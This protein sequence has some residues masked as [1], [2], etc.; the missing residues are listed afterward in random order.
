[1]KS[2]LISNVTVLAL[3]AICIIPARSGTIPENKNIGKRTQHR[4]HASESLGSSLQG[5]PHP[6]LGHIAKRM[7]PSGF[8][9]HDSE[10]FSF[11]QPVGLAARGFGRFYNQML[12]QALFVWPNLPAASSWRMRLGAFQCIMAAGG[13]E[14]V[15]WTF[16]ADF[17]RMMMVMT[18]IGFTSTYQM[19]FRSSGTSGLILVTMMLQTAEQ[20]AELRGD[21]SMEL[22][23]GGS[24]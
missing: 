22:G 8:S 24:H 5:A 4:H 9:L 7:I 21:Y 18:S 19:T 11:I 6:T 2:R 10:I 16:V 13:A 23:P 12:H 15:P 3:L 17:A 14:A 20:L 1:M